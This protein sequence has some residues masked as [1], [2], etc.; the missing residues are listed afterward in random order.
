MIVTTPDNY[1]RTRARRFTVQGVKARH[2]RKAGRIAPGDRVCWYL[3]GVAGFVATATVTSPVFAGT[4]PIWVST[5]RPDPYPWRFR[6]ARDSARRADQAVAAASLVDRLAFTRRW[7]RAHWRL[8]FQGN[9]HEIGRR[10]FAVIER[11]LTA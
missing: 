8:A 4:R 1:A 2:A 9:L 10:D 6:I 11:A 3:V 5:G 7:P